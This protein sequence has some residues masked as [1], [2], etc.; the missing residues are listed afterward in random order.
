L[1][2]SSTTVNAAGRPAQVGGSLARVLGW[3]A[4]VGGSLAGLTVGAILQAIFPLGIAG[5]VVG[6]AIFGVAALI[7][8]LALTGGRKL[9]THGLTAEREARERA[10]TALA[11]RQQGMVTPAEAAQAM[12]VSPEIA[13]EVLTAMAKR[14][15]TAVSLEVEDDGRLVYHFA[16]FRP[17]TRVAPI[18]PG[19]REQPVDGAGV[20][21][22]DV[23]QA[24]RDEWAA[25]D[26][27]AGADAIRV[28]RVG[29]SRP[30]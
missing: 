14:P 12:N 4:L 25:A 24:E 11:R 28:R 20:R 7:G 21:V 27:E 10:V 16:M 23:G 19:R 17:R 8:V 18:E 13:D 15:E 5:Y 6:G 2:L 3:M 26:D 22:G 1:P 9:H 30:G 29:A